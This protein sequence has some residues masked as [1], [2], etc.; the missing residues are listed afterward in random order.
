MAETLFIVPDFEEEIS[1]VEIRREKCYEY[2]VTYHRVLKK[3]TC[4]CSKEKQQFTVDECPA[5][6]AGLFHLQLTCVDYLK[7][8]IEEFMIAVAKKD[9]KKGAKMLYDCAVLYDECHCNGKSRIDILLATIV[10]TPENMKAFPVEVVDECL[11]KLPPEYLDLTKYSE[12]EFELDEFHVRMRYAKYHKSTMTSEEK[13]KVLKK[14][15][16]K[17]TEEL[18]CLLSEHIL[19]SDDFIQLCMKRN[20]EMNNALKQAAKEKEE[21]MTRE[22]GLKTTLKLQE[23]KNERSLCDILVDTAITNDLF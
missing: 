8:T 2:D 14:C 1:T 20:E 19:S 12:T 17:S 3:W 22:K 7:T 16:A 15:K 21:A 13:T 10:L 5:A 4:F 6:L 23:E 18:D 11:M 9:A